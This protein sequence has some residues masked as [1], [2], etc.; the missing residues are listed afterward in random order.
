MKVSLISHKAV[1]AQPSVLLLRLPGTPHQVYLYLPNEAGG[2]IR[3]QSFKKPYTFS[4]RTDGLAGLEESLIVNVRVP[5][6]QQRLS[7]IYTG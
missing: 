6:S 7:E 3:R 2:Y 5:K 1:V 4:I